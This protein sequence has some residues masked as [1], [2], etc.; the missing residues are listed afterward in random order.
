MLRCVR[1]GRTQY[2]STGGEEEIDCSYQLSLNV[3]ATT[4]IVG[5]LGSQFDIGQLHND[6]YSL[7][8]KLLP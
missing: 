6:L 1:S 7:T 4:F 5:A 3:A 2:Q 8:G